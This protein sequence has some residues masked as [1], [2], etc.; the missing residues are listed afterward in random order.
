MVISFVCYG[1][2][3]VVHLSTFSWKHLFKNQWANFKP[4]W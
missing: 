1:A 2:D 4:T 3:S